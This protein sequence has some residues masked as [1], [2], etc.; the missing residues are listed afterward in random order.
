[1]LTAGGGVQRV[2]PDGARP[3][4]LHRPLR[5]A[6]D[7]GVERPEA[8]R[9]GGRIQRRPQERAHQ[10]LDVDRLPAQQVAEQ[11]L[12]LE[13]ARH[14]RLL[15]P[16][17]PLLVVGR[18]GPAGEARLAVRAEQ[19]GDEVAVP[20]DHGEV[21]CHVHRQP[22]QRAAGVGGGLA[23]LEEIAQDEGDAEA[24]AHHAAPAERQRD[25]KARIV[26]AVH[27]TPQAVA[28]P[29]H[30][31]AGERACVHDA[32]QQQRGIVVVADQR[33]RATREDRLG[34]AGQVRRRVVE[35]QHASRE[36]VT[37]G[38]IHQ[39]L[40]G[41]HELGHVRAQHPPAR[42]VARTRRPAIAEIPAPV[43]RPGEREERLPAR[44]GLRLGDHVEGERERGLSVTGHAYSHGSDAG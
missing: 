37:A 24:I 13:A 27:Q 19:R 32:F 34:A 12:P 26:H 15:R 16:V 3:A 35:R 4:V 6:V 42:R 38:E 17:E 41:G 22:L 2:P 21:V 20:V 29:D 23:H 11:P 7:G 40:P 18:R 43:A 10:L 28:H 30:P 25:R 1:M 5:G 9:V 44:P 33:R 14:P 8:K 31:P 39:P 36:L